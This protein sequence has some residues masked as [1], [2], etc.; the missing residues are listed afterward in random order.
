M[1]SPPLLVENDE[2]SK[3]DGVKEILTNLLTNPNLRPRILDYHLN[4]R[5]QVHRAYLLKDICLPRYH[6]FSF[7]E[8]GKTPQWRFIPS[9]FDKHKT[10]LEYSI[11]K[12]VAYCLCC[13]FFRPE[14]DE[15]ESDDSFVGDG[16][17]N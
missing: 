3:Q 6:N 13:Y 9:W 17:S 11:E 4:I 15:Q 8:Y 12:N 14:I 1:L 5:D 16:F 7:K 10:W 2:G